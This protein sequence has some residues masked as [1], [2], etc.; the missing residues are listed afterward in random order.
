MAHGGGGTL[1]HRLIEDLFLH[2]FRSTADSASMPHDSAVLDMDGARI[3]FTTDSFVVS[4]LFFPGGDVGSLAV[5]GTV[6][7]LAMSGARPLYL[8]AAYILEEGF[9]M[10]L[11]RRVV[12]SMQS[13]AQTVGV[14]IVTGDTKV[15]DKG[16]GDGLFINTAGIGLIEHGLT[17]NPSMVRPGDAVLVNGDIGRHGMAIMAQREGLE[18]ESAIETDSASLAG[19]VAQ[20]LA[21]SIEIHCMR[22]LTRG[23]IASA[24][25]EIAAAAGVSVHLNESTIPVR[26]DVAGACEILGFDPL[27]VACEGRMVLFVAPSDA[28]RALQVMK[29]NPLGREA[30]LIGAVESSPRARILL[31][32]LVGGTRIVDM[33]S[34]EQLPRIC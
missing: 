17:I 18:F 7:D 22:D 21:A 33:L 14:R 32:T 24:L 3:A 2:C 27:Y 8:S 13:A 29:C 30:A 28:D 12:A 5:H 10:D 4:P 9:S 11:L 19:L 20:L 25:N 16:K 34:G 1:M 23:G 26:S 15:V 6:N 31:K